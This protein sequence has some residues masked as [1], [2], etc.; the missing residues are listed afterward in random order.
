MEPF[1]QCYSHFIVSSLIY[2]AVLF[3]FLGFLLDSKAPLKYQIL[4]H[5]PKNVLEFRRHTGAD[6][7][8][9]AGNPVSKFPQICVHTEKSIHGAVQRATTDS[10]LTKSSMF[11]PTAQTI[12]AEVL[13]T[14][15]T[16][17]L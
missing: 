3:V 1:T 7:V 13:L 5:Y 16:Q 12:H 8:G 4:A 15:E 17:P 6:D 11:V 9:I 10:I 14:P 2:S